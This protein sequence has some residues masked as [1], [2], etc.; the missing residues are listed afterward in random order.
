M[1]DFISFTFSGIEVAV[2]CDKAGKLN[3][4]STESDG[5]FSVEFPSPAPQSCL[6]KILGGPNQLYVSKSSKVSQVITNEPKPYT[7][8]APLVFY[9]RPPSSFGSSKT[10]DIPLPP[11]WG[12]APSSYYFPFFPIIGIP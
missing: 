10:F 6:A 4:A 3:V 5:S 1:S 7:L 12:F 9:T 11:E 8:S 2:K